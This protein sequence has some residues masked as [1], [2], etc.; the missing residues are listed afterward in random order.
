MLI[1][2]VTYQR[3]MLISQVMFRP[4]GRES[5]G[6]HQSVLW[7]SGHTRDRD[8]IELPPAIEEYWY[9]FDWDVEALWALDLPSEEFPIDKLLW[10]LDVPLWELDGRRYALTPRQVLRSPYRYDKEYRRVRASS[11]V[12]PIEIT[13]LKGRWLILDG[14]HRMT[15]AHEDGHEEILVRKVPRK[16]IR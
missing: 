12:F 3:A 16:M 11:L 6:F 7:L 10:H 14:V 15:R 8:V 2:R 5:C 1:I 13:R 4:R 9:A